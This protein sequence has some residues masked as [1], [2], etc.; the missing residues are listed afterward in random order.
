M[1]NIGLKIVLS[2]MGMITIDDKD[3][4]HIAYMSMVN[5]DGSTAGDGLQTNTADTSKH[6]EI[7]KKCRALRDL[8]I[9]LE[10]DLKDI[11]GS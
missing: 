11:A 2:P 10:A 3:Q 4:T 9:S 8:S 6:A 1:A 7:L 5:D